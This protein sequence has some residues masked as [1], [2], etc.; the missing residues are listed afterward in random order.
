MNSFWSNGETK[1]L[2]G[3]HT[4]AVSQSLGLIPFLQPRILKVLHVGSPTV[5]QCGHLPWSA[6]DGSGNMHLFC[7]TYRMGNSR[8]QFP[9]LKNPNT[10]LWYHHPLDAINLWPWRQRDL[11]CQSFPVSEVGT[12]SVAILWPCSHYLSPLLPFPFLLLRHLSE[13]YFLSPVLFIPLCV[14][15]FLSTSFSDFLCLCL[16]VCFPI[17]LSIC[18]FTS[19]SLKSFPL[20][21]IFFFWPYKCARSSQWK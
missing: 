7:T 15:I 6:V 19:S 18:S 11:S 17:S 14:C 2:W 16:S 10:I 13:T 21:S 8:L 4:C 3:S 1:A 5:A 20:L 9:S 12:R